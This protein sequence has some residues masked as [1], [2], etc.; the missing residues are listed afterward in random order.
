[1]N[2]VH[3]I[4]QVIFIPKRE[5]VRLGNKWLIYLPTDMNGLWEASKSQDKKVKVHI[6]VV[7]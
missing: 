1:M 4:P 5:I 6:E 2:G 7:N 3:V